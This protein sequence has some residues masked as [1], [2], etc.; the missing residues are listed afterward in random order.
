[1]LPTKGRFPGRGIVCCYAH[2]E[3]LKGSNSVTKNEY[4]RKG[5][6]INILQ[7]LD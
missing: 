6:F 5:S 7:G 1:M 4:V 2:T 3:F